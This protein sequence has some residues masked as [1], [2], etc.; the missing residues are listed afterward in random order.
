[1]IIAGIDEAGYGPL[2]GPLTVGCCAFELT[3]DAGPAGEADDAGAAGEADDAV[4]NVATLPCVWSRLKRY[5]SKTRSKTGKKIH[6]ND[7]KQVYSPSVGL[8]ELERSVLSLVAATGEWPETLDALLARVAPHCVPELAQHP[9]YARPADERFPVG[10]DGLPIKLFAKSLRQEMEAKG[11]R[12]AY[13]GARVVSERPYNRMVAA[14]RNKASVLFTQSATHLDHL[15]RTYGDRDLHVF[16]DR[17]GGR[18]SY[19][20]QLRLLF[21]DWSLEVLGEEDGRSDYAIHR[22]GR[23]VR[24]TWAEKAEAQCLPVAVASMIAKYL[25]EALMHRFNAYWAPH[26]PGVEPTAG[27]YTDGM[28]WLGETVEARRRLGVRDEDLVR[29][30]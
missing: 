25:R 7:S 18:S 17:Q 10:Q 6:V 26:A 4:A 2:L 9:W 22:G 27:Y 16:C 8:K 11:A 30:K 13:L 12:M 24:V 1:M 15:V 28:R 14:T 19:G 5:V 21:E 23:T 20:H 3:G 29:S